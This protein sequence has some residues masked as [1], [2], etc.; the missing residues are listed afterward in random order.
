LGI[1]NPADTNPFDYVDLKGDKGD[2]FTI[3]IV[4]SNSTAVIYPTISD[5][6]NNTNSDPTS[7]T[8]A[9][10]DVALVEDDGSANIVF[11]IYDGNAW[12]LITQPIAFAKATYDINNRIVDDIAWVQGNSQNLLNNIDGGEPASTFEGEIIP[13]KI[14]VLQEINEVRV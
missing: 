1:K 5:L 4:Y 11:Y 13:D 9:F 7:Y 8:P 2:P 12:N 3:D 6:N 10:L 14:Y